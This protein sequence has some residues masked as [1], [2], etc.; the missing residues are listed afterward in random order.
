MEPK[1]QPMPRVVKIAL[2]GAAALIALDLL[3]SS[4]GAKRRSR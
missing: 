4:G 3:L 2:F 1:P